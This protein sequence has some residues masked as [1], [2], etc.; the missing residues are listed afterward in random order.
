M[1]KF[2]FKEQA[3]ANKAIKFLL[4]LRAKA[5][6]EQIRATHAVS[7]LLEEYPELSRPVVSKAA[8]YAGINR[9]TARNVWDARN[10]G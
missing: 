4:T 7:A 8:P 2:K 3:D 10:H 5:V 1:F 6:K 9:L